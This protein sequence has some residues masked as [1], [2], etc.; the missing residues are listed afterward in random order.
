MYVL[1]GGQKQCATTSPNSFVMLDSGRAR[2]YAQRSAPDVG[3]A[4]AACPVN[5]MYRVSYRELK[6][7]ERGRDHGDGRTDHLHLNKGHTPLN[8]AGIDSDNNHKSSWYHYL[9]T[10]CYSKYGRS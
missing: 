4:I 5:C 7:L 1:F 10:K 3:M 6:E 9:K 2:T 8:V